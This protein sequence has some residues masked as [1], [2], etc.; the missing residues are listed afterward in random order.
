M[1]YG[2]LKW[3]DMPGKADLVV[4][5]PLGAL[6]QHGH[7]LPLLTDTLNMDEITR[8]AEAELGEPALFLPTLW[9]GASDHHLAFPGTVSMGNDT[10]AR[11]VA[12]MLES[13]IGSGFR[14]IL[15]L[16]GHGGNRVPAH[17]AMYEVQMRHRE[18]R[19]L[20]LAMTAWFDLVREQIAALPE[21]EQGRVRHACEVETSMVLHVRPELVCMELARAGEVF[22][23]SAFYIPSG[24]QPGRVS[25]LRPIDHL[26]QTGAFGRPE[27]ATAEKG[28]RLFDLIVEQ[29]EACVRDMAGWQ[30]FEPG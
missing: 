7:H 24:E 22:F 29:V 8:R 20:W 9:A 18:R 3:T 17:A 26:S 1:Q 19:D 28:A 6:E 2:E 10:Y 4:V 23:D 12:D 25:V 15:L 30:A 5:L 11:V 27:L 13:L 16:N 21:L 14:R